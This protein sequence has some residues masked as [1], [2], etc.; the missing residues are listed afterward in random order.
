MLDIFIS[1]IQNSD[2]II[3]IVQLL[4]SAV[5]GSLIG[6]ER[7][8]HGRSAGLRTH[9]LVSMGATLF[10]IISR[11][12]EI[13]DQSRIAAQ[14]VSGIGFLGAGAIM[15][16]GVTVRGLT[17]ASSLWIVAGIGMAVGGHHYELAFAATII[18]F[19]ALSFLNNFGKLFHR[20]SYRTLSV[21]V[22]IDTEHQKVLEAAKI[23][24]AKI[25]TIDYDHDTT[26]KLCTLQI[27]MRLLHKGTT[28]KIFTEILNNLQK[29]ELEPIKVTWSK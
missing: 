23:K 3:M 2:N 28:D 7:D 5:L 29:A 6:L 27:S 9:L 11:S 25:L 17:T 13:G 26:T 1:H 4:I 10:M 21:S 8:I 18:S 22:S 14:I 16:E 15:K 20:E 24:D 19:V 12:V